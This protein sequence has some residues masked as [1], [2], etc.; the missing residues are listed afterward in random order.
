MHT[1]DPRTE[2]THQPSATCRPSYI[3]EPLDSAKK[4]RDERSIR[5]KK[6]ANV[7]F[8]CLAAAFLSQES[9]SPVNCTRQTFVICLKAS[10]WLCSFE[11]KQSNTVFCSTSVFA[12][13]VQFILFLEMNTGSICSIN[14]KQLMLFFV[15]DVFCGG[16]NGAVLCG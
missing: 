4:S 11:A 7:P 14:N 5:K 3:K 16:A 12:P 8:G 6:L 13:S 1:A 10:T 15:V 2:A 9:I